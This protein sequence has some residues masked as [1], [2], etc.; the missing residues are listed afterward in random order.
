MFTLFPTA[1][2]KLKEMKQELDRSQ[3]LAD[4]YRNLY[5]LE[6]RKNLKEGETLP[7]MPDEALDNKHPTSYTFLGQG[8]RVNDVIRKNEVLGHSDLPY[9]SD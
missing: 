4:K 9:C 2:A 7:P 3:D 6:R 1:D 8:V 5:E